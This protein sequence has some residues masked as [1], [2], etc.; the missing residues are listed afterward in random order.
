M[1]NCAHRKTKRLFRRQR[2]PLV[3]DNTLPELRLEPFD[4]VPP[5]PASGR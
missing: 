5:L 1:T 3:H 4:A 2:R